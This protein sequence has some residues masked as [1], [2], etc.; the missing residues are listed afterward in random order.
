MMIRRACCALARCAHG[1]DIVYNVGQVQ[2]VAILFV[3]PLSL[4]HPACAQQYYS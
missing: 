2:I 4:G 1:D 3:A